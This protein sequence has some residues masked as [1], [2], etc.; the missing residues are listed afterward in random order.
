MPLD[1]GYTVRGHKAWF[2][3]SWSCRWYNQAVEGW[4]KG[5][6]DTESSWRANYERRRKREEGRP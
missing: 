4:Y 1:A 2:C 3:I 6:T 5:W